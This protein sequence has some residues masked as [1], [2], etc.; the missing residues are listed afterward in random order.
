[1]RKAAAALTSAAHARSASE[2]CHL[3]LARLHGTVPALR[4]W[5]GASR[6]S[7]SGHGLALLDAVLAAFGDLL[8]TPRATAALNEAA[9][10]DDQVLDGLL[11]LV[12]PYGTFESALLGAKQSVA[13]TQASA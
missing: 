2:L 9:D 8:A 5:C 11:V 12:D 10:D 3:A 6:A 1:M 13:D 4:A 7:S